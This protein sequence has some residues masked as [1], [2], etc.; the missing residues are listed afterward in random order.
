MV[1]CDVTAWGGDV[2]MA[3]T[4]KAVKICDGARWSIVV[5]YDCTTCMHLVAPN[6]HICMHSDM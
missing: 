4:E 3:G 2:L 1:M 5:M 6:D